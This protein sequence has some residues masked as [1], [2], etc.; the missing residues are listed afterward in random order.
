M[1]W[2]DLARNGRILVVDDAMENIQI[3]HHALRDEHEV[4]FA[5]D[6]EK[7]CRSRW[8]SNPT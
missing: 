5:L 2:T 1:S 4:L 3:L 7:A 6:G 8:N